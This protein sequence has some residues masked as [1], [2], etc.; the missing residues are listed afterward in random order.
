[1][2]EANLLDVA[3]EAIP[4]EDVVCAGLFQPTAKTRRIPGWTLVAVTPSRVCI[5]AVGSTVEHVTAADPRVVVA[6]DRSKTVARVTTGGAL[7]VLELTDVES[8]RQYRFECSNGESLGRQLVLE[9]LQA[10]RVEE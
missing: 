9:E 3:H 2:Q 10:Q 4:Y 8:G 5:I 6:L 7:T 1:M